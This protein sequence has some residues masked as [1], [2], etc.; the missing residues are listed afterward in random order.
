MEIKDLNAGMVFEQ[1]VG[2]EAGGEKVV[3]G[4]FVSRGSPQDCLSGGSFFDFEASASKV[5]VDFW[6]T[7]EQPAF[8]G[9][10]GNGAGL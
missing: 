5:S 4:T 1:E 9:A 10:L 6:K 2:E 3:V 8:L 7:I